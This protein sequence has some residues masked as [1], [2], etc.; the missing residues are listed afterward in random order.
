MSHVYVDCEERELEAALDRAEQLACARRALRRWERRA[1]PQLADYLRA[2]IRGDIVLLQV[3]HRA[4]H[5]PRHA[6]SFAAAGTW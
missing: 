6:A 5:T 2:I 4:V 1:L 3:E